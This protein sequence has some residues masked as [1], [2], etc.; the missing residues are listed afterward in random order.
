MGLHDITLKDLR[1][2]S[3]LKQQKIYEDLGISRSG[4]YFIETGKTKPD[5]LKI[6]RLSLIYNCSEKTIIDAWEAKSE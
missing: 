5:K 3:G 2:K 6:E 4:F 1:L